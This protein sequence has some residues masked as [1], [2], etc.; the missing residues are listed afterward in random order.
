MR[1]LASALENDGARSLS[2]IQHN[3]SFGFRKYFLSEDEYKLQEVTIETSVLREAPKIKN[4]IVVTG[5]VAN[6]QYFVRTLRARH[7][8]HFEPIIILNPLNPYQQ[9]YG[10]K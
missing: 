2:I 7:I 8:G 4:H 5:A 1:L 3:A 9:M 10:P 6:L